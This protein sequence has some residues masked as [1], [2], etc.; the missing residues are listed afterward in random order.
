[1]KYSSRHRAGENRLKTGG[2]TTPKTV[3]F[4]PFSFTLTQTTG[5]PFEQ[6]RTTMVQILL[7][8]ACLRL[9]AGFALVLNATN[10]IQDRLAVVLSNNHHTRTVVA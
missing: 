7:F 2:S 8:T 6:G 1:M 9:A 10:T 5:N 3:F 4:F